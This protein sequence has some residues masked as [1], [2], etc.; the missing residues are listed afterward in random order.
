MDAVKMGDRRESNKGCWCICA[1]G[2]FPL[3]IDVII[4]II[5]G[6]NLSRNFISS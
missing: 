4:I 5:I 1:Y 2:G 6:K 3:E